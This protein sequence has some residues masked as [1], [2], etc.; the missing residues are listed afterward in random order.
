MLTNQP[1]DPA[2]QA[3][4]VATA[5]EYDPA[6][7]LTLIDTGSAASAVRFTIDA[8]GRHA[9]QS[10]GPEG[11]ESS[12]TVYGYLG[13]SDTVSSSATLDN[14]DPPVASLTYSAIDAIGDRLTTGTSEA[15]AY[16]LPDLHGNVVATM[17]AGSSPAFSA[18]YRYDAYGVTCDSYAPSGSIESPWRYQGRILESAS[19]SA[20]LYDFSARS[21]D[22]GLGAF[23][24][25]DS[26]TGSAQNPATL[27]RYLYAGANPATLVDPDGHRAV[28]YADG[29][30]DGDIVP[31]ASRKLFDGMPGDWQRQYV[32]AHGRECLRY[33]LD[34]T[35]QTLS[36]TAVY[37]VY[38]RYYSEEWKA[39]VED[40][41]AA[42]DP[43]DQTPS[44]ADIAQPG[45]FYSLEQIQQQYEHE[46]P[47]SSDW[48]FWAGVL[49]GFIGGMGD[50]PAGGGGESPGGGNL[51][52][53]LKPYG[54][55]DGGGGHHLFAKS[56]FRGVKGYDDNDQLAIPK[57]ELDRLGIEHD[58]ITG[59]QHV[60]YVKWAK[61]NPGVRMTL[62]DMEGVEFEALVKNS[63]PGDVAREYLRQGK[64]D[65]VK[66]GFTN[67]SW[68]PWV[69][70]NP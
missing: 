46:K 41:H 27:N 34:N 45:W 55:K 4:L 19:G 15:F 32:M 47:G 49:P 17:S 13:T 38:A 25:F 31:I 1:S 7:H 53:A 24:S 51:G 65:L 6:G 69:G 28:S 39:E 36:N 16:L 37:Q 35:T 40:W 10:V 5:Y 23:T 59:T 42:G 54:G 14:A 56:G 9:T 63:C 12:V 21:Y 62:D 18:A 2:A 57:T 66:K 70:P 20:D 48:R 64:E 22:P 44:T 68:I 50:H 3:T 60:G 29:G 33:L 61:E 11:A 26:V 67:P 58:L 30:S 52:S 43:S 8:L